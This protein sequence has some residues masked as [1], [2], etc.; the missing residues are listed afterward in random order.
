MNI[1]ASPSQLKH[2]DSLITR[3]KLTATSSFQGFIMLL[4]NWTALK[5]ERENTGSR[6]STV[7]WSISPLLKFRLSPK[8][9]G[10]IVIGYHVVH[11]FT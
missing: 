4:E 1:Q 7:G 8:Y 2:M 6:D 10:C 11:K 9:I 5:K 3:G